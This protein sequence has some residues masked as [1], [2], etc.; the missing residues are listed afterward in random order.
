MMKKIIPILLLVILGCAPEKQHYKKD[1]YIHK[2][3]VVA[4]PQ[5]IYEIP[6][7]G[8]FVI[9][10]SQK[11]FARDDMIDAAKQ[12][13]AVIKSRNSGSY[14]ITKYASSNEE[15]RTFTLNVSSSPEETHRIYNS[16]ELIDEAAFYD[17]FIALFGTPESAMA[18]NY[19][20]KIIRNYPDW[21]PENS[22]I[23]QE[24]SILSYASASSSNLVSAWERA[25]EI[26]RL[27]LAKYLEKQV[28]GGIIS[29]DEEIDKLI[30]LETNRKLINMD[31]T[32]SFIFSELNDALLSY[33][34]YLEMRMT[35]Q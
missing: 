7:G 34:V 20:T 12:F 31:I 1:N 8:D 18:E 35:D 5:W 29:T 27:E 28:T 17:F 25:A 33:K 14:N 22:L 9:G 15:V 32:R 13:A 3:E 2:F 10:V 24:N 21:F 11:S 26:A 23:I 19:K 16:L 4:L 6:P 30:I